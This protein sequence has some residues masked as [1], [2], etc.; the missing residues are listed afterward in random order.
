MVITI[1]N[2]KGGVGKSTTTLNLGAG[3]AKQGKR[4]LLIDLDAQANLTSCFDVAEGT[5]RHVGRLLNGDLKF[6]DIL[7]KTDLIDLLP[8]SRNLVQFEGELIVKMNRE[9]ILKK[10][11]K[12]YTDAYDFILIDTPPALSLL[13]NN[14]FYASDAYIIA[15][16]AELFSYNGLSYLIEH[17][18]QIYEDTGIKLNGIVLTRYNDKLRGK[19]KEQIADALKDNDYKLYNSFIRENARIKESPAVKQNIFDYAP[20]SNGAKDY[21]KLTTEFLERL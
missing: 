3:L 5:D 11:L 10:A 2:N 8:S 17:V 1:A 12:G 13:T 18:N 6:K 14:A 7:F 9:Q 15:M 19:L 16:Q 21:Q 20:D 4:V